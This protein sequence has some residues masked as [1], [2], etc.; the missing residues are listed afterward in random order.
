MLL[1]YVALGIEIFITNDY[2]FYYLF[3]IY[4]AW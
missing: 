1:L 2:T 4:Y 3:I